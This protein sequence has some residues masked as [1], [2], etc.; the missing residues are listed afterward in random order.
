MTKHSRFSLEED[1][2]LKQLVLKYGRN[3]WYSVAKCMPNRNERQCKERY[4]N[5]L[6]PKVNHCSWSQE[7]DRLLFEKFKEIGPKWTKIAHWFQG[8]T[9]IMLKNRYLYLKKQMQENVPDLSALFNEE[10]QFESTFYHPEWD[11]LGYM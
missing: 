2:Q 1:Q 3:A 8:R 6:S 9:D 4:E 11:I 7:E 10:N 5:Y